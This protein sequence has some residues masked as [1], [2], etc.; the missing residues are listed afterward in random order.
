MQA[1]AIRHNGK[2]ICVAGSAL[3]EIL[4][5][6]VTG[7]IEGH[8]PIYLTVTGM[9]DLD[10]KRHSHTTWVDALNLSFG[11]SLE[12][13][14]IESEAVSSPIKDVAADSEEHLAEMRWLEE[15]EKTI[16][17][18]PPPRKRV[19]KNLRFSMAVNGNEATSARLE[20]DDE[21][22]TFSIVWDKYR[23]E[24]F[25][26]NLRTFSSVDA[27]ARKEARKW[28]DSKVGVGDSIV[29]TIAA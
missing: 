23:P 24:Q 29:L 11:D 15:Q 25:R 12:F 26:T 3:G 27:W 7:D 21:F 20:G 19:L 13:S 10:G 1:I 14:L 22:V 18:P 2:P 8:E 28:F 16:A 4:A 5:V 6:H 17:A 9:N